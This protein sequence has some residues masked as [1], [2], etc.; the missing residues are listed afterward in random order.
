MVGGVGDVVHRDARQLARLAAQHPR[1]R[2]ADAHAAPVGAGDGH[3]DAG[4]LEA[5]WKRSSAS[6]SAVV[7]GSRDAHAELVVDADAAQAPAPAGLR[8]PEAQCEFEPVALAGH[9]LLPARPG[10]GAVLGMDEVAGRA[11]DQ[12]LEGEADTAFQRGVGEEEDALEVGDE[13]DVRRQLED[14]RGGEP[15]KQG[16]V[17]VLWAGHTVI[18]GLPAIE[19]RREALDARDLQVAE[20]GEHGL[21]TCGSCGKAICSRF[22]RRASA[23]QRR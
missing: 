4:V 9:E 2:P 22:W 10:G 5:R 19:R 3:A 13:R 15:P 11:A 1:Q 21:T 6:R 14:P 17:G 20:G 23:R 7:S 18:I 16:R 8:R 12:L